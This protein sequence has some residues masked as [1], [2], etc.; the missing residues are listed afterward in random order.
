MTVAPG[1]RLAIEAIS[2]AVV[3]SVTGWVP[4]PDVPSGWRIA[5]QTDEA[6]VLERAP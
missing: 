1:E 2:P 3:Q 5:S 4:R 6:V